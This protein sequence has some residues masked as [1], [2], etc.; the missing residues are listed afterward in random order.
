MPLL[1]LSATDLAQ[2]A[3]NSVRLKNTFP[4]CI[5]SQRILEQRLVGRR[6]WGCR[7]RRFLNMPFEPILHFQEVI[8]LRKQLF[9]LRLFHFHELL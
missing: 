2:L 6:F 4:S 9:E 5:G 1:G 8:V 7:R 3:R